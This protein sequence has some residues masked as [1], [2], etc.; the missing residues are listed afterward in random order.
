[1]IIVLCG[2][3]CLVVGAWLAWFGLTHANERQR[4][5]DKR[6]AEVGAFCVAV[7]CVAM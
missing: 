2:I 7:V 3:A 1:M 6:K 5:L 4:E